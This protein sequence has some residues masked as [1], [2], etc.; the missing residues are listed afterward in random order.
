MTEAEYRE[1]IQT[2]VD[3]ARADQ[4]IA[5]LLAAEARARFGADT[6]PTGGE[7]S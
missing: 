2:Y 3:R 7:A 5:E 4:R 6:D 1:L